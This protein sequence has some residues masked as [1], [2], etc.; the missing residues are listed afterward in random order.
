G[1]EA[2]KASRASKAVKQASKASKESG[3]L[4]QA[5]REILDQYFIIS[6]RL[7][8]EF[9]NASK[10]SE[11]PTT[12]AHAVAK[13]VTSGDGAA[14]PRTAARQFLPFPR[15]VPGMKRATLIW[16]RKPQNPNP[17]QSGLDTGQR[18]RQLQQQPNIPLV[19][20]LLESV[21]RSRNWIS[22]WVFRREF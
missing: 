9:P 21:G 12:N 15:I 17:N 18:K 7:P 19:R 11:G 20:R 16:N 3:D 5:L 13:E 4:G 10:T 8:E 2:S 22:I 6:K 1:K 14:H